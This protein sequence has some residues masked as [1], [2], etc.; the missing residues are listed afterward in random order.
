MIFLPTTQALEKKQKMD[1]DDEDRMS[2]FIERQ[3]EKAESSKK[4]EEVNLGLYSKLYHL[5]STSLSESM[6]LIRWNMYML[7]N[8]QSTCNVIRADV[9]MLLESAFMC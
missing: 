8:C 2:R 6:L 3:I 1:L 9:D 7:L 4:E 5:S